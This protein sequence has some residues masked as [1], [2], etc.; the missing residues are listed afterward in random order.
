MQQLRKKRN[1]K[2]QMRRQVERTVVALTSLRPAQMFS[3]F[4]V[5]NGDR[6]R[7]LVLQGA[8]L[9]SSSRRRTRPTNAVFDPRLSI[10]SPLQ[11]CASRDVSSSKFR[12]C[13]LCEE[14][15]NYVK[16]FKCEN[17][18]DECYK[19]HSSPEATL[20]NWQR[21]PYVS[22]TTTPDTRNAR[23]LV[24][25]VGRTID[26]AKTKATIKSWP[27]LPRSVALATSGILWGSRSD[28]AMMT[29]TDAKWRGWPAL[30][31]SSHRCYAVGRQGFRFGRKW[32]SSVVGSRGCPVGY[33]R[34]PPTRALERR[35]VM[36]DC[37]LL[38][39]QE[40]SFTAT[41]NFFTYNRRAGLRWGP[42]WANTAGPL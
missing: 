5:V 25:V 1:I 6:W 32:Q 8:F 11:D 37:E 23:S 33:G 14:R 39:D 42:F 40:Y 31:E 17:F 27:R 19:R 12:P 2:L 41:V 34:W 28:T 24:F 4:S 3:F 9:D 26:I 35:I 21:R 29:R 13:N 18:D 20:N 30:A 15:G 36:I 16:V 22:S 7:T 10:Y 38:T